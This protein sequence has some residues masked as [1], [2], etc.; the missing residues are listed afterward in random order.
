[1][2]R[3][4]LFAI[5]CVFALFGNVN[6]QETIQV[7][8]GAVM[9]Y[10][11]PISD[12]FANSVSQ[13][14]YTAAELQGKTGV[15]SRIE[16][17][18]TN[19]NSNTRSIAV[20]M[21]NVDK[22][23]FDNN[24]DWVEVIADDIVYDGIWSLPENTTNSIWAAINL[25]KSFNYTGGN[26]LVC[27]KDKT[28][29]GISSGY[30]QFYGYT[31][32]NTIRSIRYQG[33]ESVDNILSLEGKR[34][35]NLNN[36]KFTITASE[37]PEPTPDPTPEPEPEPT[38][39]PEPTPGEGGDDNED[40]EEGV[41]SVST[42]EVG[43][44]KNPTGEDGY[45]YSHSL[46][47]SDY[48]KYSVSQQIYTEEDLGNNLG[49]IR[50]IAFKL[51]NKVDTVVKRKYEVYLKHTSR[52]N[53]IGSF[54]QFTT[55]DKVFDGEVEISGAKDSWVTI[56]FTK[57]FDYSG[58]NLMVFVYDKDGNAEDKNY[59][60]F[61]A[62]ESNVEKVSV[63][64]TS[65]T[66]FN[67]L[68]AS[69]LKTYTNQFTSKLNQ[70]RF[71]IEGKAIVKV[72]PETIDLGETMLGGYWSERKPVEVSV[73][74]VATTVTDIKVDNDF[75]VLPENIDY[76]ANPIVVEIGYSEN[77]TVDGEVKGN[78]IVS[79]ED[80]TLVV[81]MTANAYTPAAGDVYELAKEVTLTD[82]KYTDTPEV[83]N[84]HDNYLLP[85]EAQG[86]VTPDAVYTFELPDTSLL[87]ARVEGTNAKMAIYKEDFNGN[88]GPSN[89]NDFKGNVEV[90]S[91]FFF[92]FNEDVVLTGWTVKAYNN[93]V[94]NWELT[95]KAGP[96]G[97][98]GIISYSYRTNV[99]PNYF[100]ADNVIVTEK[101]YSIT[102]NS[103]LSFD[104][105]CDVLGEGKIDHVNVEVSKDG[106]NTILIEKVAPTSGK[107]TNN[108]VDLG[109]KFA[110]LGLEYGDYH[111]VLHHKEES[112]FYVC[113]DNIRLSNP[114]S[115]KTRGESNVD[116]I[117]AV[118]YPAGKYYVVVAAESEFTFEL[119]VVD[120]ENLPA[121]PAN[122][123]A[124]TIDEFSI[125]LTWE[126][127]ENATSYNIYRNDAF[128]ANVKELSYIDEKLNQNSDYCYIVRG[129]NGIMES[130]ASEKACAKTLKL[131]LTP[132][133]EIFAEATSTST[134]VLTW[135]KVEKAAGYNIYWGEEIIDIVA[136]TTY[137]V[138]GLEPGKEYCYMVTSVNKGIE[139]LDKSDP[140]CATTHN[141]VPEVPANVKVEATSSV[142]VKVSWDEAENAQRY[143]IYSADTL[144]AKTSYTYYNIVGLTPDTE[145]CYI[146]KA[147][148]GEVES[149]ASEKACGKTEPDAIAENVA[150]FNIY[151]NPVNDKLYIETETEIEEVVV[152]DV[153]GRRQ[154]T[155]TPSHQGNLSVDVTNLNSG[156]Y[157]VKIVAE[158]GEVVKR[159][160]KK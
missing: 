144:V 16:F 149:E 8:T 154:V 80:T 3:T 57:K 79:Y 108:V 45:G 33:S 158:N 95:E 124:T 87:L 99:Q 78:L 75:F 59:H 72:V 68:D 123:V 142:S 47:T 13:Q 21:K 102:E 88:G 71:E 26:L 18:H 44:D 17:E 10:Y 46:P 58:G 56:P 28:G 40:S 11:M 100:V 152:Y 113:V 160:I 127:A 121:I 70:V 65:S 132:P 50:S 114:S 38:P 86:A 148:N 94:N 151:P 23:S 150:A 141:I 53:S 111:I 125:E 55:E 4:L 31:D 138:E 41:T 129:Y 49:A 156:V 66:P 52:N 27:V 112:K 145:Y 9:L 136:D 37:E 107:F 60:K 54:D 157:F 14:I 116:E 2:K 104:A 36:I 64:N 5:M 19:G 82:G 131:T 20:Y 110:E 155:E 130:V 109:A 48:V 62:Y 103:K 42:I 146:V 159:F 34:D 24:T 140:V 143:Y 133:T 117:Y 128:V 76:T 1:M 39:D 84:L 106:E 139:S 73:K 119:Q 25:T 118:E 63:F 81:P 22:Q 120:S 153:Y 30:N 97:S 67:P 98:K 135:S 91:E 61:Y 77:A 92:D 89:D 6:A 115:A 51:A 101:V 74:A 134:I 85:G 147:V 122:V 126:A 43:S 32:S 12:Y 96:D 35:I 7:G 137:T 90:K 29:T 93:T 105:M 15:I 83:A 69:T